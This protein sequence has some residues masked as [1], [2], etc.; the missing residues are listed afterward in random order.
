MKMINET[1]KNYAYA[2]I[3]SSGNMVTFLP[4]YQDTLSLFTSS[5]KKERRN[6]KPELKSLLAKCGGIVLQ[7]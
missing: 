2:W 7:R 6:S 3:R 4:V 5:K 1:K